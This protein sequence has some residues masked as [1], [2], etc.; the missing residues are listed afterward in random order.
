[1]QTHKHTHKIADGQKSFADFFVLSSQLNQF[2]HSCECVYV[3]LCVCFLSRFFRVFSMHLVLLS[4]VCSMIGRYFRFSGSRLSNKRRFIYIWSNKA[5]NSTIFYALSEKQ[6]ETAIV[7]IVI[8]L[9]R[10]AQGNFQFAFLALLF[11]YISFCT[12]TFTIFQKSRVIH[13]M[14]SYVKWWNKRYAIIVIF[15]Q[16]TRNIDQIVL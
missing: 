16:N 1:M 8:I 6:K 5:K 2:S 14:I 4:R 12:K 7:V 10:L 11:V 3:C 9:W 13:P 15:S